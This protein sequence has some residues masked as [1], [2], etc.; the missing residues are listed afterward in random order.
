M[1]EKWSKMLQPW[2]LRMAMA[3]AKWWRCGGSGD[4]VGDWG[5]RVLGGRQK[6]PM[7]QGRGRTVPKTP[8]SRVGG[9]SYLHD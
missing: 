4:V 5:A 7:S 1:R 8:K 6:D 9:G 3:W 2:L